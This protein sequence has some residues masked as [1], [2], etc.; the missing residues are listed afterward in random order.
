MQAF[1]MLRG[2]AAPIEEINVDTN[3]ICP[4]RFN[5]TLRGPGYDRIL[6]HDRRFN[7]DG[8]EKPDFILNREPYR[9]A[10]I[11]VGGRNFGCG[12][13]RETAVTALLGFGIRAV[14]APAFGDIFFNNSLK[15]GLL[16]VVLDAETVNRLFT[17]LKESVGV[18]MT[19][20]LHERMIRVGNDAP[21]QFEIDDAI[22]EKLLLGL[23]DIGLT[24]RFISQLPAFE[25]AYYS[26]TPWLPAGDKPN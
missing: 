26:V 20:D 16:P 1:T 9:R 6:F 21:I 23:D 14:I 24:E 10:Q 13:S 2:V 17:R 18:D 3:Q 8:G 25:A 12:S 5:K 22:R 7:A 15:N 19:I 11:L 4:S